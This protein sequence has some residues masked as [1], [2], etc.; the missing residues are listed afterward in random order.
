[1]KT[2]K[3][4]TYTDITGHKLTVTM[5]VKSVNNDKR[6][7]ALLVVKVEMRSLIGKDPELIGEDSMKYESADD[8]LDAFKQ[9][10][11]RK[12]IT[13]RAKDVLKSYQSYLMDKADVGK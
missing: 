8:A 11:N 4:V 13:Y 5:S 10:D 7:P 6:D 2:L 9:A 12:S 3:T 1:M